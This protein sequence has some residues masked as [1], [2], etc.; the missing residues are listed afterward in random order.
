[1]ACGCWPH[2]AR[3]AAKTTPLYIQLDRAK[4]TMAMTRSYFRILQCANNHA[5]VIEIL[6]NLMLHENPIFSAPTR[7]NIERAQ[8]NP[9]DRSQARATNESLILIH[10]SSSN[11]LLPLVQSHAAI[12]SSRAPNRIIDCQPDDQYLA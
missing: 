11:A 6:H 8:P 9:K 1:M 12:I 3:K 10:F 4:H 2:R 5:I 7:D